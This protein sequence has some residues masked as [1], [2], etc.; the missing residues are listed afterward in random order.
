MGGRKRSKWGPDNHRA[1]PAAPRHWPSLDRRGASEG[2]QSRQRAT[3][4]AKEVRRTP[5]AIA[6][7][8]TWP[9]PRIGT[10]QRRPNLYTIVQMDVAGS[11]RW[12]GP[13]L[14]R[15]RDDL[16]DLIGNVALGGDIDLESMP[17][18]DDH[19]DGVRLLLPVEAAGPTSVIDVFTNG[20]AAG[21]SEHRRQVSASAR[22]RLRVAFHVGLVTR[23]RGSWTGSSLVVPARLVN[24]KPLRQA[25]R[26]GA[27]VDLA[28]AVSDGMYQA[29]VRD[30]FGRIP[31]TC[32]REVQVRVKEYRAR[33]WLL[34]PRPA[35]IC[36]LPD[37][38]CAPR[39]R[40]G[41]A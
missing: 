6:Q 38:G 17:P 34:V 28:A 1:T 40:A 35:C 18:C 19:G 33:A 14:E 36:A 31:L 8:G 22:I 11:A 4:P 26:T 5:A 24:S 39:A 13:S 15:M 41:R 27:D 32:Y 30:R 37:H 21:L 20:L 25:L 3:S 16:F 9:W 12:D 7:P 10:K 29:V 23:H 2:R